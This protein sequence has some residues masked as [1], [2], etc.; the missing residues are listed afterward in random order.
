[1]GQVVVVGLDIAKSVFQVHGIEWPERPHTRGSGAPE[2]LIAATAWGL[3]R[4]RL[5]GS[6]IALAAIG[7]VVRTLPWCAKDQ[8][9][10]ACL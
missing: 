6:L 1:M 7:R 2:L 9:A 5:L 8:S 4:A 3:G 10:C